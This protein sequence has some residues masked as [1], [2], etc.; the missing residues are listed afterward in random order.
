ML[1]KYQVFFYWYAYKMAHRSMMGSQ[2]EPNA[3]Q[4]CQ[5]RKQT[6]AVAAV[7]S[8]FGSSISSKVNSKSW[9]WKLIAN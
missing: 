1:L 8:I 7:N 3:K 9:S 5:V 2:V 4:S 6:I